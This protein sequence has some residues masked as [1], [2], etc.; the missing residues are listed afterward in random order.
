[1]F[2]LLFVGA[3]R[4]FGN[5]VTACFFFARDGTGGFLFTAIEQLF[6]LEGAIFLF[7]AG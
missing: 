4:S 1:M 3:N 7:P 2:F 6:G 5:G